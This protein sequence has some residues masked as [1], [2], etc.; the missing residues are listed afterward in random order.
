MTDQKPQENKP[1]SGPATNSRVSSFSSNGAPRRGDQRGGE[2]RGRRDREERPRSEFDQKTIMTRRVTRVTA[3]GKR[4]NISI[5]LAIGNHRGQIGVGTGKGLDTALAIEKA[6]RSAKRHLINIPL[7]KSMSISHE[8]SSKYSS[9]RVIV[10][11]APR[12][13]LIAGSALRSLLELAGIKDVNAKILSGS[14]NKLN[15]ARATID[16][17]SQLKAPKQHDANVRA[18]IHDANNKV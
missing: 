6:M 2:R 3:G 17:L 5:V 8:V 16:A 15:I 14:K 10:M 12:R 4:F 9:A 7:T 1:A 13:G 18:K 11:P